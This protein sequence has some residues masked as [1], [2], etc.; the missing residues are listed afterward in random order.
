MA[1]FKFE[2]N[3]V[4]VQHLNTDTS[5]GNGGHGGDSSALAFGYN[6]SHA[7][8]GGEALGGDGGDA[9]GGNGNGL[10]LGGPGGDSVAQSHAGDAHQAGLLNLNLFGGPTGGD[11]AAVSQG[12]AGGPGGGLGVGGNGGFAGS[13]GNADAHGGDAH[14]LGYTTAGS[15]ADGGQGGHGG[16][17][18]VS[19]NQNTLVDNNF[20]FD[21]SFNEDNHTTYID[22]SF[23]HDNYGVD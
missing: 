1:D 17:A 20:R 19:A 10:G 21:H 13:G 2:Q 22:H 23:N 12:G 8:N 15:S 5:G 16:A 9:N 7:G 11:S 4:P 3:V 14:T 18:D 6:T